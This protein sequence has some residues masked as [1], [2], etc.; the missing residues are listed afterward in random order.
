MIQSRFEAKIYINIQFCLYVLFTRKINHRSQRRVDKYPKKLLLEQAYVKNISNPNQ[1]SHK[2]NL[3]Q[4]YSASE[5]H[6]Q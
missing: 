1:H 2:K 4:S 6:D 5:V 3:S